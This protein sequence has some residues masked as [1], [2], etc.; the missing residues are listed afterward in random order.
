[1]DVPDT[2][3]ISPAHKLARFATHQ[4]EPGKSASYNN[5]GNDYY[6]TIFSVNRLY[7]DRW[8]NSCVAIYR[9]DFIQIGV[10]AFDR[11]DRRIEVEVVI[12]L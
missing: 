5:A 6:G 11:T 3:G 1:M 10:A 4:L 8:F 9:V 7:G 12:L 2:R